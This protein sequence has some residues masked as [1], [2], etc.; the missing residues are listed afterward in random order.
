[1]PLFAQDAPPAEGTQELIDLNLPAELEL[2]LL[3]TLVSQ[4]LELQVLYDQGIA[5]ERV[6]LKAPKQ[7][8]RSLLLSILRSAL[9]MKGLSLRE[10]DT[11]G[12]LEIVKAEELTRV[13]SVPRAEE[14][15]ESSSRAQTRVF[16]LEHSSS[17][18]IDP[19]VQKFLTQ[20]GGNTITV[21]DGNLF[22]V[23]DYVSNLERIE[24]LI[25]LLDRAPREVE[26]AFLPLIYLTAVDA[27]K[28]LESVLASRRKARGIQSEG[29]SLQILANE[30][31]NRLVAIG[32]GE[33]VERARVLLQSLD[34]PS[35][36]QTKTYRFR[37]ASPERIDSLLASLLGEREKRNYRAAIDEES[38]LLVVTTT[39]EIHRQVEDLRE[40]FDVKL[41]AASPVPRFYELKNA[42]AA[43]VLATLRALRGAGQEGGQRRASARASF[44]TPVTAAPS[45]PQLE[46]PADQTPAEA[47]TGTPGA[48][49]SGPAS[50]TTPSSSGFSTQDARVVSDENTN[51]LI[52][53]ASEADHSAYESLIE[54]LDRR[55]PQVLIE[56]ILVTVDT[57][58][59]LSFGVE[60]G[61][62]GLEKHFEYVSFSSFGLSEADPQTGRLSLNPGLGFNGAVLSTEVADA[63]LRALATNGKAEVLSAPRILV[64]DNATGTLNSVQD[65]PF[66]SVNASDT[67]AT[68]SFGGFEEAGTVITVTP[69]ISEGDHLNLEYSITLSTFTGEGSSG[70]PP[71]RQRNEVSSEITIPDGHAVVVGGLTRR[72]DSESVSKIPILG[73]IPILGYLFSNRTRTGSTSTLF[74]FIR[75]IILRD[76]HFE[77]L[78]ILSGSDREKAGIERYPESSPLILH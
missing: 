26:V 4:E 74:A 47:V 61:G 6:T 70:V 35:G 59:S 31:R 11:E 41:E 3:V 72:D 7:V 14:A 49:S 24:S 25:T 73:D 28:D 57:S 63:V 48:L 27:A 30:A 21:P 13:A 22:I 9:R 75:P 36:L 8:P 54:R 34:V 2:E 50:P 20:P 76:D 69:Q 44:S 16:E 42:K 39:E 60:I 12:W 78:K 15:S 33:E 52:V 46:E 18:R 32:S 65:A 66:T 62:S 58:E 40:S 1:M 71:P 19:V 5:R 64:N 56:C 68:T 23:T 38:R 10:S 67:V 29:S 77:D 45:A 43:E 37:N 55:R 53:F 51:S 17:Q